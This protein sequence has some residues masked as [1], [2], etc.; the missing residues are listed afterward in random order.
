M[1]IL[2]PSASIQNVPPIAYDA[3]AAVEAM[4]PRSIVF[5]RPSTSDKKPV[6][7]SLTHAAMLPMER[8]ERP[9]AYD[10]VTVEK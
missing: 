8:M 10:P 1:R 4:L 5:L 6:G 7:T 9:A 3:M 2:L